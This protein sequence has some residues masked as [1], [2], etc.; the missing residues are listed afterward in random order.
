VNFK[1]FFLDS[2]SGRQVRKKRLVFFFTGIVDVVFRRREAEGV[3]PSGEAAAL[4]DELTADIAAAEHRD[5]TGDGGY[6]AFLLR[7]EDQ[8]LAK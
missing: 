6:E 4:Y 5:S 3:L 2:L 7:I 1:R 8:R